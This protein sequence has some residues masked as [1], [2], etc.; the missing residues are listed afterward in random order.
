MVFE[1][2]PTGNMDPNIVVK[3]EREDQSL[4]MTFGDLCSSTLQQPTT[5]EEGVS[6]S[7]VMMPQR[8]ISTAHL[9]LDIKPNVHEMEEEDAGQITPPIPRLVT[10][11]VIETD[12]ANKDKEENVGVPMREAV[13][14][15]DLSKMFSK[16]RTSTSVPNIIMASQKEDT[17]NEILSL[18]VAR[19]LKRQLDVTHDFQQYRKKSI[20]AANLLQPDIHGNM[21][22]PNRDNLELGSINVFPSTAQPIEVREEECQTESQKEADENM[23]NAISESAATELNAKLK[24]V[25]K[26]T[27]ESFKKIEV[28]QTSMLEEIRK[29]NETLE[30]LLRNVGGTGSTGMEMWMAVPELNDQRSPDDDIDYL[31]VVCS[32]LIYI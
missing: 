24:L 32:K 27:M 8:S 23:A 3:E 4:N 28:R 22:G 29:T 2:H 12:D 30:K 15:L 14:Q 20:R 9:K 5:S 19:D 16:I 17:V 25:E 6:P 18:E 26:N 21:E 1:N 11:P 31:V 13:D 10:F 7:N